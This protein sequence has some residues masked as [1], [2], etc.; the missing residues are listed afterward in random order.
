MTLPD[1]GD[2]AAYDEELPKHW[3]GKPP[4]LQ[5]RIEIRDHDPQW[6]T[7]YD[8]EAARIRAALGDRVVLVIREPDWFEHRVFKG[9]DTNVNL[10]VF[11]EGSVEVER[12]LPFRDWL[13]A[14]TADRELYARAKSELAARDWKYVQQYADA[15]SSVVQEIMARADA[16]GPV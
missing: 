2:V 8:R 3:V 5:G 6:P 12:M 13:R 11:T 4:P 9:P 16:A 7:L 15:K 14:S 10:H 1:P